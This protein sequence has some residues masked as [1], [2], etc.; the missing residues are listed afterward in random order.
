MGRRSWT[1][2]L[3]LIVSLAA[4]LGLG[5]TVP[6]AAANDVLAAEM[7]PLDDEIDQLRGVIAE[8]ERQ[9][10]K[11]VTQISRWIGWWTKIKDLA[12]Q[13]GDDMKKSLDERIAKAEKAQ[14]LLSSLS[15]SSPPNQRNVPRYGWHDTVTMGQL[16]DTL[17]QERDKWAELIGNAKAQWHIATIGWITGEAIQ[18]NID[19]LQKQIRDINQ[20]I[21]DGT[22]Q[23]HIVGM[24]WVT[25]T[26][27]R[28]RI[29]DIERQKQAIRDTISAGDYQVIIPGL[30]PRTRKTLDAEI[31]AVEADLAKRREAVAKGEMT[32]HRPP[33]G[34]QTLTQLQATLDADAQSYDAMKKTVNDGI[35]SVW[36]VETGWARRIDLDGRLK[37]YEETLAQTQEALSKGDYTAQ[38]PVGWTSANG[39][40]KALEDLGKQ[41]EQPNLEPKAREAI[42]KLIE[43]NQKALTEL[44]SISA[45]DLAIR[46]L[47]KAEVSGLITGIMK[48][49]RPDFERREV[50]R[51]EKEETLG[52]YPIESAIWIKPLERRLA[53]LRQA[54]EWIP[55]GG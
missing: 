30:G 22:L 10:Q 35:Y 43:L 12:T 3:V 54:K 18:A 40:K 48:L 47:E 2:C 50:I 27:L 31:A 55:T 46:A 44:Q 25:A 13:I 1:G 17:K 49:A 32:I 23:V 26:P 28:Q 20:G 24:G 16:I 34:W 4:A 37:S 29:A 6:R 8:I 14:G 5:W 53:R 39:I 38:L 9:G 11:R 41:L 45:Y 36:I 19:D 7:Q 33:I 21:Q 15:N 42:V 51:T 52:E